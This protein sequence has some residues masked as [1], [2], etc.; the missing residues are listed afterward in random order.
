VGF[1]YQQGG[2]VISFIFRFR[3]LIVFSSIIACLAILSY[4]NLY[5][6]SYPS[7]WF[8][9]VDISFWVL[10]F[11]SL[12]A[13]CIDI[14]VFWRR[15]PLLSTL[16]LTVI[17]ISVVFTF[18]VFTVIYS[19]LKYSFNTKVFGGSVVDDVS[20]KV[21]LIA[22]LGS[23]LLLASTLISTAY[24]RHVVFRESPTLYS[25]L[26]WVARVLSGIE[27]KVL[28]I[29]SFLVGFTTRLY[30]EL[31]YPDLP[32]GWDT[33]EFIA[34]AR[35]FS[36]EPKIL[37][38][39]LWLGGWRN[40][41]PLLTWIPGL[42]SY[43]GLDP[44]LFFKIY[45]PI[46]VGTISV[47]TA[48]IAYRLSKSKWV[49]LAASLAVIFNPYILG[50]SQ[51]WHRHTLGVATLLAYMYLCER[52]SKPLYRALT[53]TIAILAYELTAVLALILS[54][55]ELIASRDWRSRGL[56]TLSTSLSLLALLWYIGAPQK[57]IAAITPSG[58]YIAGMTY[59]EPALMY[60]ITA[61]LLLT[62][63][64]TI[65]SIWG[66]ISWRARLTIL[67]TL[68]AFILPAVSIIAPLFQ[69]RW[70]SMLLTLLTPYTI[71]GL[72]RLSRKLLVIA[73]IIVVVLGSAYPFT[74]GGYMYFTIL[75][76]ANPYKMAPAVENITDV[77]RAV[78]VIMK[79]NEPVLTNLY[80]YPLLHLYIRNPVNITIISLQDPTLPIVV[81][82]MTSNKIQRALVVTTGDMVSQLE[83]FK[84]KH[85]TYAERIRCSVAYK[86][87]TLN[88]YI[89][90]ILE[91]P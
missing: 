22:I 47:I 14:L 76:R 91:K 10:F 79:F 44:W 53:L 55:V 19:L 20:Y 6:K 74:D 42:L 2:V 56:F 50:Q 67:V 84:A 48:A 5:F 27:L 40:L 78:K 63:S 60:T 28:Y 11:G 45:P 52:G 58:V 25:T 64:L 49:A 51:Q 70:F 66:C 38:T 86:G 43:V 88:T 82:Y 13:G 34:V 8:R 37:T 75:P 18:R 15:A 9:L 57:P 35:D 46:I 1:A 85:S 83:E 17:G 73:T 4:A 90:E 26:I 23:F 41:P 24:G 69:E 33:L 68:T 77:E 39:Y 71:V 3:V 89:I 32:I 62:P 7:G 29:T 59:P 31:K 16:L 72:A 80:F 65:A 36:Q 12:I 87:S 21:G 61:T 30:P 54:V 81:S